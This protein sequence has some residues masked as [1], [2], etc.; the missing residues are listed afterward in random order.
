M[1]FNLKKAKQQYDHSL[2]VNYLASLSLQPIIE[3]PNSSFAENLGQKGL[4]LITQIDTIC[5]ESQPYKKLKM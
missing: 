2:E 1:T 5:Y 3:V 4:D